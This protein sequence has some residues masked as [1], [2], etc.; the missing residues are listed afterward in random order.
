MKFNFW[1]KQIEEPTEKKYT[2]PKTVEEKTEY[3]AIEHFDNENVKPIYNLAELKDYVSDRRKAKHLAIDYDIY[4]LIDPTAKKEE[5]IK[6][7]PHN[8]ET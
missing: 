3:L 4:E 5:A 7:T 2:R 1:K 8:E 6:E